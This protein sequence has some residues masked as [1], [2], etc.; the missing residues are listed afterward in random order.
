MHT[1][2]PHII[3]LLFDLHE[4]YLNEKIFRKCHDPTFFLSVEYKEMC[5]VVSNYQN[6]KSACNLKFRSLKFSCL[7]RGYLR[8]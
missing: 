1:Y 4:K 3:D 7:H 6:R 8:Y 5:V 2:V